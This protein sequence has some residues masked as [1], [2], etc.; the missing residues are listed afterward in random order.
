MKKF[1]IILIA[2]TAVLISCNNYETY[3]DKKDKERNAISKFIA[4]SSIMVIS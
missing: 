3:G 4:D 2:F 1:L